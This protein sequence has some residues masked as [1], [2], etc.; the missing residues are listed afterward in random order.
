M[1]AKKLDIWKRSSKICSEIYLYFQNFK[2]YGFKDQITRSALF[3][4]SN[5]AEGVEESSDKDT[6]NSIKKVSK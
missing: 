3:V 4:P 5:I 2:D 6:V 1:K